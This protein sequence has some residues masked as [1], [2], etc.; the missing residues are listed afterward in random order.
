MADRIAQ[1]ISLDYI[2]HQIDVALQ[3]PRLDINE[4]RFLRSVHQVLGSGMVYQEPELLFRE[5]RERELALEAEIHFG[6][7]L[8]LSGSRVTTGN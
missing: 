7:H 8:V 2:D 5:M 3:A 1:G 4:A 6:K